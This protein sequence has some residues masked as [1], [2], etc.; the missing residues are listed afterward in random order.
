MI[1]DV[2]PNILHRDHIFTMSWRDL[3]YILSDSEDIIVLLCLYRKLSPLHS[4]RPY[5][6][7]NNIRTKVGRSTFYS[8]VRDLTVP[9]SNI[10]KSIGYVQAIL[11]SKP[12]ELL[13][14]EVESL[15]PS[16]LKIFTGTT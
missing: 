9:S 10:A 7:R 16:H 2:V 1:N 5:Q 14:E 13:Q 6:S 3:L 11:L 12:I 15:C 4:W 8:I